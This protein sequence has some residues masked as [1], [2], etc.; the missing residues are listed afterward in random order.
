MPEKYKIEAK[1]VEN[2][3]GQ[4]NEDNVKRTYKIINYSVKIR[5][6]EVESFLTLVSL[7]YTKFGAENL[8]YFSDNFRLL[9][10]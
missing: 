6:F 7:I 9:L 3:F 5:P 10:R 8:K 1:L 4:I 2:I